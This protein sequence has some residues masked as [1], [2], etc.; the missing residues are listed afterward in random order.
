VE[1]PA[2]THRGIAIRSLEQG[3][4]QPESQART[5]LHTRPQLAGEISDR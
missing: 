4:R 1:C 3:S 5:V 2:E